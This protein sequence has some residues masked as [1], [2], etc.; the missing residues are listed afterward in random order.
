MII[1]RIKSIW[2]EPD[3]GGKA[4]KRLLVKGEDGN[5]YYAKPWQTNWELNFHN[6]LR[7]IIVTEAAREIGFS[8]LLEAVV[9]QGIEGVDAEVLG[10]QKVEK[11]DFEANSY[12]PHLCNAADVPRIIFLDLLLLNSDRKSGNNTN[13]IVSDNCLFMIDL[14]NFFTNPNKATPQEKRKEYLD[15]HPLQYWLRQMGSEAVDILNSAQDQFAQIPDSWLE[16]LCAAIPECWYKEGG[17]EEAFDKIKQAR[18]QASITTRFRITTRFPVSWPFGA[19]EAASASACD[20]IGRPHG[21]A[22]D[23]SSQ[24]Q[25]DPRAVARH[26]SPWPRV[27]AL[28]RW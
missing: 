2:A 6:Q 25:W 10:I 16:E 3:E 9:L 1:R 24:W 18:A 7:P 20:V 28:E 11:E 14:D 19:G 4:N 21:Y 27:G 12:L 13:L 22:V 26:E 23:D 8:E 17:G 15:I 5:F